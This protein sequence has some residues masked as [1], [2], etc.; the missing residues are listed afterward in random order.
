MANVCYELRIT[1]SEDKKDLLTALLVELGEPNFVEGA[2]DCDIEFEYGPENFQRDYYGE[3]A[4][5]LPVVVYG[6]D[7]E[8][9]KSLRDEI[10]L[11]GKNFNL[12]LAPKDMII[13]P[14]ADQN[15]RE[16]WKASFKP[17]DIDG[18]CVVLPPWEDKNSFPHRYKIIIDPGMAF[19]TGQHETTRLC[20][21]F[22]YEL[23]K[24]PRTVFDVGTGSG[25]LA[26]AAKMH[27]C[28]VILGCDI[29]E[30]SI[31]IAEENAV[32]N[33]VSGLKFTSTPIADLPADAYDLVFANIQSKPLLR[34]FPEIAKRVSDNG[35]IIVSGVLENERSEFES[36]IATLGFKVTGHRQM[37]DWAG[38]LCTRSSD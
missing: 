21:K 1:I 6:E 12:D 17:V 14:C 18:H 33:N 19:G 38:L 29:D 5:N 28:E 23:K 20:L 34:I 22:F 2:I 16:S 37:G 7:I 9:L 3:L 31:G 36:A 8:K 35:A 10:C 27:G 13:E 24:I 32:A 30:A 4:N 11:R 25:I 15:W 26:I